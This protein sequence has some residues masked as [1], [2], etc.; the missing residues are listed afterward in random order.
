MSLFLATSIGIQLYRTEST[1]IILEHKFPHYIGY[2][3]FKHTNT[4]KERQQ[5]KQQQQQQH[6]IFI[7]MI[8]ILDGVLC[9][10]YYFDDGELLLNIFSLSV[11]LCS[12]CVV[13][14]VIYPIEILGSGLKSRLSKSRIA[15]CRLSKSQIVK[16]RLSKSRKF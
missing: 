2:D 16:C 4:H 15:K 7:I 10:Y 3:F 1:A 6:N 5:Q 13:A 14:M 11:S 8:S 9:S 12:G